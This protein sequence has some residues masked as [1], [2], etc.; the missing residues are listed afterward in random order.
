MTEK[1]ETANIEDIIFSIIKGNLK[2]LIF[3]YFGEIKEVIIESLNKIKKNF[4][5]EKVDE[6]LK[7]VYEN[8][9]AI[10]DSYSLLKLA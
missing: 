10:E 2:F 8:D 5:I 6:I 9:E 4:D 7:R 3:G 1:G